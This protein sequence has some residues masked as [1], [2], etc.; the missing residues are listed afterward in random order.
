MGEAGEAKGNGD[1][2]SK[3]WRVKRN[4]I[5]KLKITIITV[6]ETKKYEEELKKI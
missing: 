6:K 4:L 5:I 3:K 2:E 1:G